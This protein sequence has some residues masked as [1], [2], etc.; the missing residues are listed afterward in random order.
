[1]FKYR[2]PLT[3][4]KFLLN[5]MSEKDTQDLEMV[6]DQAANF[7]EQEL[8]P[9]NNTCDTQGCQF[10][11]GDVTV[12]PAMK[13]AL[14]YYVES[15]WM[16]ITMPEQWGGQA[17]P[18][19][20]G[21][22][23]GEMLT[24]ANQAFSMYPALTMS[25]CKALL[26]FGSDAL[27]QTYL[28]KMVTGEWTGTMCMTEAHCGSD[29]GLIKTSAIEIRD[30]IFE[31]SG[32]KI[33][34]SAGEH[35]ASSNIVHLVLARI[36]GAPLGI[37]GLSL[38]LVPKIIP[39]TNETNILSCIGIE[40]KMGIHANP[41]CTM[42][43]EAAKGHLV[44]RPNEGIKAMFTMMNEMRL[45]T[46]LQGVGLSEQAFQMSY[47][48]ATERTQ[49]KTLKKRNKDHKTDAPADTLIQHADIRR[50]LM[51]QKAFAE[52]GRAF[53]Q[54]CAE[55]LDTEKAETGNYAEAAKLLGLLTPIAKAFLTETGLESAS[56]AI[57]VYGGHGFIKESGVEQIYRD[58]RISTLYEGTTGIQ[59]LDLLGRKVLGDQAQTL[60]AFTKQV[61]KLC[62]EIEDSPTSNTLL[63]KYAKTLQGYSKEWPQL[64]QQI[65]MKAMQDHEEVGAA[66]YDFLMYSGYATLAFFWLKMSSVSNNKL[67]DESPLFDPA[68]LNAKV[69]TAQFY[70]EKILPRAQAHKT[71][72]S[73]GKDP[74]SK[75]NE[76]EWCF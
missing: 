27:K 24:S 12:P 55:L 75:M 43:F 3:D 7:V 10:E 51:T 63:K 1:M 32:S 19:T 21:A 52:G 31:I 50:M 76:K 57:Q 28:P 58:G 5:T 23:V 2:A 73:S 34:I 22:K 66:A 35:D 46:S 6:L 37:K 33:F 61:Y 45:G 54:Y 70:F 47:A 74:V 42:S 36:K 8:V 38:F 13:K 16:S 30:N 72:M 48:Y 20:I 56:H 49:G 53:C 44:G 64:A 26:A 14:A 25:A 65:G 60:L 67:S 41:T 4:M 59:A 62:K 17:L 69:K 9:I 15:G 18:E 11:N 40:E 39:E 68:F 71:A 29:L